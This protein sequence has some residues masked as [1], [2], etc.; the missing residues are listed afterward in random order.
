MDYKKA[1]VDIEAGN[2]AARIIGKL[3]K[4]TFNE[5]VVREL[6]SFGGFYDISELDISKPVLV[7]S[8]DGI[9]TKLLVAQ[10]A[11]KYKGLGYD[12][13]N[14]CVNDIA[15]C[16][17]T[18]LFFM[19][20]F[21]TSHLSD[22]IIE[23]IMEGMTEALM[24]INCPLI[25]GET[26]ELPDLYAPGD[27]DLAGFI[28]GV[29]DRDSII[30]GSSI[31]KYDKIIVIPS[32]GL[33][34]NGYTLARKVVFDILGLEVKFIPPQLEQ[35]IGDELLVP[36]TSYLEAIKA[37]KTFAKG[38]AHITGGGLL[39]NIARILPEN[40]NAVI[41][42]SFI[43]IPPIFNIIQRAGSIP[44]DEMYHVF[45]MGAGLAVVV[46]KDN[47][48]KALSALSSAGFQAILCGEIVEGDR[49]VELNNLPQ[50]S[51]S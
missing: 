10:K 35:S 15:V 3:A 18:P 44:S 13:V 23:E 2:K 45:N 20:Y 49:Q 36:H 39:D 21:A 48:Q 51:S 8:T 40:C 50:F 24:E 38:I 32:N 14:H 28:T 33:H 9:G 5:R 11:G 12:I 37:V 22:E 4:K 6:G 47:L 17:A 29:V 25:G 16:G 19:D 34:T 42:V 27:F 31:S 1:G 7:S 41:D 46:S 30:D 43:P 26:A